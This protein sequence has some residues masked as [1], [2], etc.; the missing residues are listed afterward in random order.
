MA[1]VSVGVLLVTHGK[2]GRLLIDTVTDMIGGMPLRVDVL[3][4]RRVQSTEVLT[5]QGQRMIDRLDGGDGVLILTDVFGA[6]PGNIAMHLNRSPRVR[7]VAGL[8]LPML[9]RICN[10][11]DR[12]LAGMTEDALQGGRRGVLMFPVNRH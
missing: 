12:D 2:L 8:N 6:T 10:Y 7:M 5:S 1:G 11:P 9:V 3:E 4:V